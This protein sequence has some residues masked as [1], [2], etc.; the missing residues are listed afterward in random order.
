MKYLVDYFQ[1]H[2]QFATHLGI[3]LISVS[4]GSAKAEMQIQ[5]FHLNS[6]KVVHGGAI[7]T[8]ADFVFAAASNAYGKI[9]LAINVNINY[10]KAATSGKIF[11]EATEVAKHSKLG[12]YQVRVTD[13]NKDLVAVFQGTAYRKKQDLPNWTY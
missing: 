5:D 12:T 4:A 10:I 2:D 13:E 11:A 1:N 7:F 3:K 6:A 9:A 8:L